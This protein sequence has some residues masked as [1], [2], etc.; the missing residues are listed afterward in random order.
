V[1]A[2]I[3]VI[4]KHPSSVG[5]RRTTATGDTQAN[6]RENERVWFLMSA[7]AAIPRDDGDDG[8]P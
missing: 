5:H 3:A 4:G 7:I 2:V 6:F 8:D 1:I